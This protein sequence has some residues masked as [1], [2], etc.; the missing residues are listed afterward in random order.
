M[1]GARLTR[2]D[3]RAIAT[4]LASGLGY[5]EIARGLAR[6]ISTVSREVTRNGGRAGYDPDAAHRATKQRLRHRKPGVESAAGPPCRGLDTV[7][8]AEQRL[9][10]TL[11]DTGL[12]RT[13]A[14]VLA[15]LYT[16]DQASLSAAHLSRHLQIS[17]AS[18]SK[19]IGYLEQQGIVR[20]ERIPARRAE[21]YAVDADAWSQA[22]LASAQR[23]QQFADAARQ[24]AELLGRATPAGARLHLLSRIHQQLSNDITA[25]VRHWRRTLAEPPS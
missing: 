13:P 10:A 24:G 5:A 1:P 21:R 8:A 4:G 23:N 7:T 22:I 14:R 3:R 17:S 18:V 6:P 25:Q 11:V 20:R 12:A 16:S 15:V 9:A 19:A 2:R